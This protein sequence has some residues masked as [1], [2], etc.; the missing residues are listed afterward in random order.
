VDKQVRTLL[1]GRAQHLDLQWCF[2]KKQF[3]DVA[4]VVIIDEY[5]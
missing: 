1:F 3:Y 4:Q 2:K 5:V